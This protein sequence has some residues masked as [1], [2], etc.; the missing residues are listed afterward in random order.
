MNLMATTRTLTASALLLVAGLALAGCASNPAPGGA[1]SEPAT[2]EAETTTPVGESELAAAWLDDGRAI[3]VV[4]YGSSSCPPVAGEVTAD[5]QTVTVDI[6][7]RGDACTRDNVARAAFVAL[8]AGVDP[9]QDV[10]VV[11]T[12]GYSG[13]ATLAG[14]AGLVPP[15][16]DA[17]GDMVP[18][19]GWFGAA[20][21][22]MLTWG[23]SSCPPVIDGVEVAATGEV[24]V[25]EAEAPA[26]QVC[27][28]DYA[29]RLS[30][31][32]FAAPAGEPRPDRLVLVPA[33]GDEQPIPLIG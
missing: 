3:G 25:T 16:A 28:M 10:E 4:A 17:A 27:T 21:I 1:A 6:T 31:L 32:E 2:P 5:G 33:T 11:V 29:P 12:G 14:V 24:R 18:S 15:A 22:V 13:T 26:D 8:P 20:G 9:A 19:A 23:S 7:D 30:V